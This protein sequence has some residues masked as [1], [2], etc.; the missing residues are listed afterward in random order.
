M[1]QL[2]LPS[3][4]YEK[5]FREAAE[6]F[7]NAEKKMGVENSLVRRLNESAD[8]TAFV[9]KLRE[10]A[11]GK[12]LP[13]GY[14]PH[15]VFWLVY[16]K[17]LIGWLNIR[18][19]LNDHL[20][21]VGGHIGYTIRPSERRKGYGTKILALALSEAKKLGIKRVRITCND[22]NIGSR[23]I[24]EKNGGIFDGMAATP[25]GIVIRRYWIAL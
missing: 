17:E 1:L 18:H 13:E 19:R 7:R 5:S 21:E 6:E 11:E 10:E 22:D 12:S 15:T 25:E 23:K 3:I 20:L 4:E 9:E 16:G 24:I 2:V 8:F 14:V